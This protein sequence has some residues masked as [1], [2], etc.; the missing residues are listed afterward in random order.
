[1]VRRAADHR[2]PPAMGSDRPEVG[3]PH[4]AST[5]RPDLRSWPGRIVAGCRWSQS[6]LSAPQPP[7]SVYELGPVHSAA[8]GLVGQG[9]TRARSRA[10]R[11]WSRDHPACQG[12]AAAFLDDDCD[13]YREVLDVVDAGRPRVRESPLPRAE[14][15]A[16]SRATSWSL[17]ARCSSGGAVR[18]RSHARQRLRRPRRVRRRWW[19]GHDVRQRSRRQPAGRRAAGRRGRQLRRQ[20]PD[21]ATRLRVAATPVLTGPDR[22]GQQQRVE[23]AA[24]DDQ[25]DQPHRDQVDAPRPPRPRRARRW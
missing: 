7:G 11:R 10:G 12:P 3:G 2:P 13:R 16:A 19:L 24:Y 6:G 18:R 15:H 23:P 9:L 14:G 1:M 8:R 17:P 22:S 25:P 4:D 20:L 5:A 21:V